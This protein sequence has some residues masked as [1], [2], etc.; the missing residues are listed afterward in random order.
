MG[1]HRRIVRD[2]NELTGKLNMRYLIML[3]AVLS[4]TGCTSMMIGGGNSGGYQPPQDECADNA[5]DKR[6]KSD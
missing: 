1:S 2:G 5:G 4:L 3:V 6:C